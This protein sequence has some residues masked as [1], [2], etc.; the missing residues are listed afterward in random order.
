MFLSPVFQSAI[1]GAANIPVELYN[2]DGAQGAARGA[3]VGAGFYSNK[4]AFSGLTLLETIEPIKTTQGEYFEAYQKW[5][6]ALEKHI[7]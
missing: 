3:G 7:S 6:K 4:D 2:T 5:V 1:A